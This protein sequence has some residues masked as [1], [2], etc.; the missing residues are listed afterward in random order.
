MFTP[1]ATKFSRVAICAW[2]HI[3]GGNGQA[4]LYNADT[5]VAESVTVDAD[6]TI[7]DQQVRTGLAAW[8]HIVGI[9]E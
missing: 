2:T 9:S 7:T 5:R 4:L 3:A 8:T 6:G 1:A